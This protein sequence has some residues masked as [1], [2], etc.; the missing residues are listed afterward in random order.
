VRI[1]EL[2]SIPF[3]PMGV[4]DIFINLILKLPH[5]FQTRIP[6]SSKSIPLDSTP[7]EEDGFIITYSYLL[8]V[9]LIYENP[10]SVGSIGTFL[11]SSAKLPIRGILFHLHIFY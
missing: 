1:F 5:E 4:F 3:G 6:Y 9:T 2:G 8:H 7:E 11:W 10:R